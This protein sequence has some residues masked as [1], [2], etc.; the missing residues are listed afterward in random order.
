MTGEGSPAVRVRRENP[1]DIGAVADVLT[2]AFQTPVVAELVA[3]LR[4]SDWWIEDLSLT[5]VRGDEVVGYLLFTSALVDALDRLVDVLVLSPLAVAPD[6]QRGGV[7]ATLVREGLARLADRPEPVVFLEGSPGYYP[8][9]GFR[10]ATPLG[11]VRPSPRIPEEAFMVYP[12]PRYDCSLSGALVY[13][14]AF[15]RHDCVGPRVRP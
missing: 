6:H 7:G 13:P 5:A 10:P 2:A 12:M 3:A 1:E 15:W 8:R 9:F 14:D 4:R 11:F